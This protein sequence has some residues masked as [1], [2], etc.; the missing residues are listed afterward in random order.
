VDKYSHKTAGAVA[1]G[2]VLAALAVVVMTLGGMIPVATYV[3]PVLCA[4]LLNVIL[5]TCGKRIAWA[6]YVAVAILSLLMGP[7]LEA[8]AL[9]LVLGY[10]PIIKP[11]FDKLRP[12]LVWKLAYF[13]IVIVATYSAL[14]YTMGIDQVIA[15]YQELGVIGFGGLLI[16]INILFRM[17][18]VVLERRFT[19][20]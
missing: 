2:G 5:H 16:A 15:E 17:V 8:K 9:F 13:N 18:D 3:I 7:D 20:K 19:H 12:R 6:W 1:L 14:F 10:Y 11:F 4:I